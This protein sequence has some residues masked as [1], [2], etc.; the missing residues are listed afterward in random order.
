MKL[1]EIKA[2]GRARKRGKSGGGEIYQGE[3]AGAG[4]GSRRRRHLLLIAEIKERRSADAANTAPN[5][6]SLSDSEP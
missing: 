2:G 3:S 1:W 4:V 5:L 6:R